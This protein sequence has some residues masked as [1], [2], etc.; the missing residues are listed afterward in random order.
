MEVVNESEC[1]THGA[2]TARCVLIGSVGF[3]RRFL[4]AAAGDREGRGRVHLHR[5]R[6]R[7][8]RPP[9]RHDGQ[10]VRH[11]CPVLPETPEQLHGLPDGPVRPVRGQVRRRQEKV[12]YCRGRRTRHDYNTFHDR[13]L[14]YYHVF[15][16]Q[17]YLQS[18]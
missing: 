17:V 11:G 15:F 10:R 5:D 9:Q 1:S 14:L 13:A 8:H 12:L 18:L 3:A 7:V 16:R 2:P 4:P 6:R